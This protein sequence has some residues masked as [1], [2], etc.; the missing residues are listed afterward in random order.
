MVNLQSKHSQALGT[1][2]GVIHILDLEGNDVKRFEC[3]TA[4]VNQLSIDT[5][6]EFVASASDDG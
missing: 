6:G 1:H 2:W 4:T 5:H 3:H